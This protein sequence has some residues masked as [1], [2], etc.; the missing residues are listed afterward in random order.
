MTLEHPQRFPESF[1]V[2]NLFVYPG[3]DF[4][5]LKTLDNTTLMS[6]YLITIKFYLSK[7]VSGLR[8]AEGITS[9]DCNISSWPRGYSYR[10]DQS[11]PNNL[12]TSWKEHLRGRSQNKKIVNNKFVSQKI[13]NYTVHKNE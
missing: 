5:L 8:P 9:F 1:E 7:I 4:V 12:D 6:A 3:L 13:K 10:T 11:D 2:K